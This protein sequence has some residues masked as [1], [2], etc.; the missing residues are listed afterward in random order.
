[1]VLVVSGAVPALGQYLPSYPNAQQTPAPSVT[2]SGAQSPAETP[3]QDLPPAVSLPVKTGP[4][5]GVA[6]A[7]LEAFRKSEVKFSVDEL[8][9]ILQDKRHE[10]WV[11]TAYPD[12]HTAQ[13]LIGAGFSLDLPERLHPQKD[14]MNP[15]QFIEPSSAELWQAAGLAPEKLKAILAIYYN[16]LDSWGK[17]GFRSQMMTL[18]SQITETDAQALTR[19]GVIQAAINAKAYCRYFRELTASQ[20]MGMTQLVYQMGVNMEEFT[21]FLGLINRQQTDEAGNAYAATPSAQYWRNVQMSL[22]DS[23]WAK[24]YKD[25]ATAVVAMFDPRYAVSPMTAERRV[26]VVLNPPRR[27]GRGRHGALR[28]AGLKKKHVTGA[29]RG[30]A[31]R[32]RE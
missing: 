21:T 11:L 32:R 27:H 13:P 17:Q 24:A 12:P 5:D 15:S 22:I 1:M 3:E 19:I 9:D 25:R 20:Q 6:L 16:R 31:R 2:P 28:E 18:D 7:R 8:V 23:R 29:R 14:V 10:G 4:S 26:Y 30:A